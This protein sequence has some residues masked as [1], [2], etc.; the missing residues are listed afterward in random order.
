[1]AARPF[2]KH[3]PPPG[4]NTGLHAIGTVDFIECLPFDGA[5][6]RHRQRTFQIADVRNR[7][8]NSTDCLRKKQQL[9]QKNRLKTSRRQGYID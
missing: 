4:R 1:M 2:L 7:R 3:L 9:S 8:K 6:N 5:K